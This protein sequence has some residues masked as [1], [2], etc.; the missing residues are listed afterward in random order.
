M[1]VLPFCYSI[2]RI[3]AVSSEEHY[4]TGVLCSSTARGREKSENYLFVQHSAIKIFQCL[5]LHCHSESIHRFIVRAPCADK[6]DEV[7]SISLKLNNC[8][9]QTE[10]LLCSPNIFLN[11][12]V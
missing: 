1:T 2:Y 6:E 11:C 5:A 10:R 4:G 3:I 12:L 9:Y 7:L 8:V